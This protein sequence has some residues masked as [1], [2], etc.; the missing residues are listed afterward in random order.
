MNLID[1]IERY[2]HSHKTYSEKMKEIGDLVEKMPGP[3]QMLR[4]LKK[5]MAQRDAALEFVK[6][7]GL[8]DADEITVNRE[9]H[10]AIL[11]AILEGK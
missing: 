7:N 8:L 5:C 11:A 1:E 10:N 6:D 4:A 2:I 3:E 9:L